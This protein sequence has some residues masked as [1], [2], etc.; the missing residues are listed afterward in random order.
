MHLNDMHL[1]QLNNLEWIIVRK[2]GIEMI[3][4]SSHCAV[5]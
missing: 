1:L 4:R 5:A 3:P 2:F